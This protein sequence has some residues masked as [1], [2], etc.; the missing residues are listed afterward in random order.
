MVSVVILLVAFA[1]VRTRQ[2]VPLWRLIQAESL[3]SMH[4]H[5]AD[6]SWLLTVCKMTVCANGWIVLCNLLPAYPFDAAYGCS[7]VVRRIRREWDSRRSALWMCIVSRGV[8]LVLF[9]MAVIL[10]DRTVTSVLP[11]WLVL[12]VLSV[13]I[14]FS[15]RAEEERLTAPEEEEE[16]LGYDF[17][18][19]Y[20]SLE[21]GF[22]RR[23][24]RRSRFGRWLER[25][26]RQWQ[27][28]QARRE[29]EDDQRV[30]ALLQR[31]HAEGQDSLSPSERAFLRRVSARYRNRLSK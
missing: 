1:L 31:L 29:A 15:A 20:T 4:S 2:H 23:P 26:R 25:L 28:R 22:K 7:A 3:Q 14:Y 19:G 8:A 13:T 21:K 24:R 5:D 27:A 17:S 18:Q 9:L 11:A 12:L 6:T 16:S 30:D 10:H